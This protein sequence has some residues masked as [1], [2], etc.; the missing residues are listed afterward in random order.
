M[1]DQ[2]RILIEL[3]KTVLALE[4]RIKAL[5]GSLSKPQA[6]IRH[7]SVIG[8]EYARMVEIVGQ[9]ANA[10]GITVVGLM[11][12]NHGPMYARPRQEAMTMCRDDGYSVKAV[13]AFF[14]RDESTISSGIKSHRA[15]VAAE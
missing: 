13:A 8:G 5:E 3:A 2:S 14:D 4:K 6:Q 7:V 1:T 12:R 10:H 11:G 9:V 15:R